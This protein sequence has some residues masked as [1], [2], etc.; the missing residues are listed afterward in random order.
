MKWGNRQIQ[1]SERSKY[2]TKI[3][4]PMSNGHLIIASLM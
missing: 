1:L 2:S 3:N 4:T